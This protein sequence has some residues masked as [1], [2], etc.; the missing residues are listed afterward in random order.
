MVE[1]FYLGTD[2]KS[3]CYRDLPQFIGTGIVFWLRDLH[4][5]DV[6]EVLK[7]IE[8]W[9]SYWFDIPYSRFLLFVLLMLCTLEYRYPCCCATGYMNPICCL[10]QM[11]RSCPVTTN[12]RVSRVITALS[13]ST[14]HTAQRPVIMSIREECCVCTNLRPTTYIQ[15]TMC[16]CRQYGNFWNRPDLDQCKHIMLDYRTAVDWMET[17]EKLPEL[18][19][20]W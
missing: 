4:W 5:T 7:G 18:P 11:V 1:F 8:I 3:I 12:P 6:E 16:V 10:G 13:F 17:A 20:N 19:A 15:Q 14:V 9:F 2:K